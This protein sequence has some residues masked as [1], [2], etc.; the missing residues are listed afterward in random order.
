MS[1]KK[2]PKYGAVAQVQST[3]TLKG[4][5]MSLQSCDV[6]YMS[7]TME[8]RFNH[9]K[10]YQ[11]EDWETYMARCKTLYSNLKGSDPNHDKARIRRIKEQFFG[12]AGIAQSYA[13]KFM[14][15]N[16]LDELVTQVIRDDEA[17]VVI[18]GNGRERG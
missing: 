12:G 11:R 2:A 1:S 15:Q 17:G 18:Y 6:A 5:L 16:D 13:D 8:E 14:A 4:V 3:E 9:V 10:K 7:T